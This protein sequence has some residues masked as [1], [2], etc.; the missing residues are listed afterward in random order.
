MWNEEI[1]ENENDDDE[2]WINNDQSEEYLNGDVIMM[3][4]NVMILWMGIR[5]VN[6]TENILE[7]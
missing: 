7:I 3:I 1:L 6:Y 4:M 5:S 2:Y